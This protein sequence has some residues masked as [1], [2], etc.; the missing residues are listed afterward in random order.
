MIAGL[1]GQGGNSKVLSFSA[2]AAA[3][4][5]LLFALVWLAPNSMEITW[6][7]RP[8][9]EISYRDAAVTDAGKFAWRPSPASAIVFSILFV[10]SVLALSNLSPFIYFQF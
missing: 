6:R 5:T 9:L 10:I 1:A 4:F 2:L 7:F 3:A 8:A